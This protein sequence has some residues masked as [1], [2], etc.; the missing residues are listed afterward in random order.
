MIFNR[1]TPIILLLLFIGCRQSKDTTKAG[2]AH[3][4]G[5]T[6]NRYEEDFQP[7]DH[8]PDI[9]VLLGEQRDSAQHRGNFQPSVTPTEPAEVVAGFR[10]QLLSSEDIDEAR[11]KKAEA[12]SLFP[13]EWIYMVYDPPT[14]KIRAGNF[15]ARFEADRFLKQA[16]E[17][18]Y[19]NA[20]I[21]PE[22]VFKNPLSAPQT[23]DQTNPK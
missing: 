20:W 6:S 13:N 10:V 19:K 17:R 7:A 22:K 15:V 21:V 11:T 5:G 4:S 14:Y 8:D 23:N 12:E 9:Y 16:I 1:L 3:E 2:D 18:G